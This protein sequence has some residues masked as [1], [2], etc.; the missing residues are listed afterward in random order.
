M[1]IDELRDLLSCERASVFQYDPKNHELF[2]TKAHGLPKSLRLP[3]DL[4]LVGE[5][6]RTR[7]I[8][9]IPDAYADPRFNQDVDKATGFRTRCVLT[10]PLIDF[11]GGLVG[12]AQALNKQGGAFGSDD[13]AVARHLAMQAAQALNRASLLE[14][15]RTKDKLEADLAAARRIQFAAMPETL[16]DVPGY[17]IAAAFRPAEQTGGDAYDADLLPAAHS[18]DGRSLVHLFMGDATGHGISAALSVVQVLAMARI[19]SRLGA[20]LGDGLRRVNAQVARDLP[21]GRFVT[22]FF[23]RLDPATHELRYLSAGQG[24]LLWL[25]AS[26]DDEQIIPDAVPLGVD[27]EIE[28]EQASAVHLAPGEAFAILSDGFFEALNPRGDLL[29]VE[30]V[31]AILRGEAHR[32]ANDMVRALRD[33]TEAYAQGRPPE[34]DQTALIVRRTGA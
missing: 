32:S 21:I 23:G 10:I 17:Q 9:N 6:A 18:G 20:T 19:A 31:I 8:V 7:A 25:R 4:G 26:G 14:A 34:D 13:E 3:A 33:E 30:R 5:A 27:N 12:V 16:P 29:G 28:I 15:Q 11:Q 22:A 2:A 1:I 24:P